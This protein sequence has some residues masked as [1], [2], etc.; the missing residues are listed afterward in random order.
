M[1]SDRPDPPMAPFAAT[2]MWLPSDPSVIE[3]H[4]PDAVPVVRLGLAVNL[5]VVQQA[6]MKRITQDED[7]SAVTMRDMLWSSLTAAAYTKEAVNILTGVSHVPGEL[8][9]CLAGHL[10]C[11]ARYTRPRKTLGYR[12]PADILAETVAPT[13]CIRTTRQELYMDHRHGFHSPRGADAVCIA[14][15]PE[16][17]V[18]A[19]AA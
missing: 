9:W 7:Q 15:M 14:E 17:C 18:L 19:P 8:R 1:M 6:A 12:T 4:L 5:L 3:E 10:S 2:R 13:D 16:I 11:L